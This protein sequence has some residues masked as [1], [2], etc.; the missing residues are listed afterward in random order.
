MRCKCNKCNLILDYIEYCPICGNKTEIIKNL[1]KTKKQTD[2]II[3][4]SS[5][6]TPFAFPI[7][8]LNNPYGKNTLKF[9]SSLATFLYAIIAYIIFSSLLWNNMYLF[10]FYN[11]INFLVTIMCLIYFYKDTEG[12]KKLATVIYGIITTFFIFL[13]TSIPNF[14]EPKELVPDPQPKNVSVVNNNTEPHVTAKPITNIE[15]KLTMPKFEIVDSKLGSHLK[16]FAAYYEDQSKENII[17]AAKCW[18]NQKGTNNIFV[19]FVNDKS[20]RIDNRRTETHKVIAFYESTV[21]GSILYFL[22]PDGTAYETLE[23]K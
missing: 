6:I 14:E 12:S 18:N 17:L 16:S 5:I 15:Q 1:F 8:I 2:L 7:I 11:I 10:Y 4:I 9:L 3:A 23:I 21:N 20:Y 22:N 13:G 19:Y